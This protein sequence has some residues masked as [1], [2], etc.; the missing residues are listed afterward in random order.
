MREFNV[1]DKVV[2][3]DT[4]NAKPPVNAT[5]TIVDGCPTGCVIITV[6]GQ[7]AFGMVSVSTLKR[8]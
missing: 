5:V 6:D 2:Y 4:G 7:D 8:R 3:T 1:G